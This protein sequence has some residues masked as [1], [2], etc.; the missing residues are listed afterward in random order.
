M[1]FRVGC[2]ALFFKKNNEIERGHETTALDYTPS[3]QRTRAMTTG[4]MHAPMWT[5]L[6]CMPSFERDGARSYTS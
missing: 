6:P 5:A 1:A 4:S 2:T 3:L